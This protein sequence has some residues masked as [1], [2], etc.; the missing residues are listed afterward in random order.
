MARRDG[1]ST[2]FCFE[3]RVSRACACGRH[4]LFLRINIMLGYPSPGHPESIS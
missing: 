3:N 1:K 2:R 4:R